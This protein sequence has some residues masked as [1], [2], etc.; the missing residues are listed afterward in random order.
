MQTSAISSSRWSLLKHRIKA[1]VSAGAAVVTMGLNPACQIGHPIIP[2]PTASISPLPK[3]SS[4]IGVLADRVTSNIKKLLE[5]LPQHLL[6]NV[7]RI[8][9]VASREFTKIE[10]ASIPIP[11]I[12]IG[13][14]EDFKSILSNLY[15]EV[16]SL[17]R[18]KDRTI[19]L[20]ADLLSISK[21]GFPGLS[22]EINAA[23]L[24]GIYLSFK[25]K[26][27]EKI[28]LGTL[29]QVLDRATNLPYPGFPEEVAQMI[30]SY[31]F[32]AY[33]LNG[34]LFRALLEPNN[35]ENLLATIKQSSIPDKD[36]AGEFFN[37]LTACYRFLQTT[38]FK[39][40]ETSQTFEYQ[41][42][43]G[44]ATIAYAWLISVNNLLAKIEKPFQKELAALDQILATPDN[45]S[46]IHYAYKRKMQ[47]TESLSSKE[48]FQ[49]VE[50]YIFWVEQNNEVAEINIPKY[51]D[52][53]SSSVIDEIKAQPDTFYTSVAFQRI[54]KL[55]ADFGNSP[56]N[57]TSTLLEN[58][59][60]IPLVAAILIAKNKAPSNQ[61]VAVAAKQVLQTLSAQEKPDYFFA[62]AQQLFSIYYKYLLDPNNLKPFLDIETLKILSR[63]YINFFDPENN[64]SEHNSL[65]LNILGAI[66]LYY[67]NGK[68]IA[69]IK[70]GD[71][72]SIDAIFQSLI[73]SAAKFSAYPYLRQQLC[74]SYG[75]FAEA[76]W[77]Y[78]KTRNYA[79]CNN[80][81][82]KGLTSFRPF[83]AQDRKDFLD[84]FTEGRKTNFKTL[85]QDIAKNT[86]EFI[87]LTGIVVELLSA[88]VQQI[89]NVSREEYENF[90]TPLL[91]EIA[92][93]FESLAKLEKNQRPNISIKL[94]NQFQQLYN[95]TKAFSSNE[96]KA[97]FMSI[98][99]SISTIGTN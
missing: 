68:F 81:Y 25:D 26:K 59:N 84:H 19:Y 11:K 94:K 74:I 72:N 80:I 23:I 63:L 57:E 33:T 44:Y 53:Y 14:I 1:L 55:L 64:K 27:W 5:S 16:R 49:T 35:R 52:R 6:A 90:S 7:N 54:L 85:A 8:E 79:Q 62:C 65:G 45:K 47:I 97:L 93:I 88:Y 4:K 40:P 46:V 98:L 95:Q 32:I 51:L 10:A 20:S 61:R 92:S 18:F 89:A 21:F 69:S 3:I 36:Y 58:P 75:R 2:P 67:S 96:N 78:Y 77:A 70:L 29:I 34:H 83:T 37:Q 31:L 60:Y 66:N 12:S 91:K 13:F 43:A 30:F 56:F 99:E 48:Y 71:I 28:A 73:N 41:T 82:L 38:I 87:L 86:S 76:Y 39:D 15:P 42:K 24:T 50:D 22:Y 17:V 9:F